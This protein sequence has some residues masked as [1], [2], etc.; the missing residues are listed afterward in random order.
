M[1]GIIGSP[2]NELLG[3]AKLGGG[4]DRN[5]DRPFEAFRTVNGYDFNGLA[6]CIQRALRVIRAAGP[7]IIKVTGELPEAAHATDAR[8]LL[9][10]IDVGERPRSLIGAPRPDHRTDPQALDR[11]RQ[12]KGRRGAA[13]PAPQVAQG[14]QGFTRHGVLHQGRIGIE[15]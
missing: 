7:I 12:E 5:D 6:F 8:P 1:Q 2:M 15:R 4:V 9:Q 14:C 10:A 3:F 13:H 11:L